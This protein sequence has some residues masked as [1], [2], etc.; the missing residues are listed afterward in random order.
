MNCYWVSSRVHGCSSQFRLSEARAYLIKKKNVYKRTR[1]CQRFYGLL[2]LMLACLRL[3][4]FQ[5]DRGKQQKH[6]YSC[7]PFLLAETP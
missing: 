1:Q 3:K 2:L 6:V 4:L 5:R 7:L